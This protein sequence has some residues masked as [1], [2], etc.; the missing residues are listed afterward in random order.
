MHE[1]PSHI[2]VS[3]I[4]LAILDVDDT[5]AHPTASFERYYQ[6]LYQTELARRLH[7]SLEGTERLASYVGGRTEDLFE[8]DDLREIVGNVLPDLPFP[9]DVVTPLGR[10]ALYDVFATMDP[11][12]YYRPDAELVARLTAWRTR[13]IKL[14]VVT[15]TVRYNSEI[16]LRKI[17]FDPGRDFDG[18]YP[19]ERHHRVLPKIAD[20]HG[21]Y[22]EILHEFGVAPG[23]AISIGDGVNDVLPALDLG[24]YAGY[25]GND[26]D[27]RSRTHPRFYPTGHIR[28]IDLFPTA[29]S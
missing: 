3:G 2:V 9:D 15:N 7:C 14:V 5:L 1:F 26:A 8:A 22:R 4:Q 28:Y 10:A 18:Y 16:T 19:W 27:L 23:H 20:P 11:A 25:V 29:D 12:R 21:L 6:T 17:G 13:G 24:M